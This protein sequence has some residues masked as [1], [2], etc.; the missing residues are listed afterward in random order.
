M[1]RAGHED[2]SLCFGMAPAPEP[3]RWSRVFQCPQWSSRGR[4][5]DVVQ[6]GLEGVREPRGR[7]VL[8]R[9]C[10]PG[11]V[12]V[13]R[14]RVPPPSPGCRGCRGRRRVGRLPALGT[15]RLSPRRP[16]FP[17]PAVSAWKVPS[18]TTLSWAMTTMRSA[19]EVMAR[20]FSADQRG[21]TTGHGAPREQ[22]GQLQ[23]VPAGMVEG[24]LLHDGGHRCHVVGLAVLVMQPV[25][26]LRHRLSPSCW[27]GEGHVRQRGPRTGRRD[28]LPDGPL[29]RAAGRSYG[30][31]PQPGRRGLP[32]CDDPVVAVGGSPRKAAHGV[33]RGQARQRVLLLRG[34]PASVSVKNGRTKAGILRPRTA[35]HGHEVLDA[36]PEAG[37]RDI[38]PAGAP[39]PDQIPLP[40]VTVQ[41]PQRPRHDRGVPALSRLAAEAARGAGKAVT[42]RVRCE[43]RMPAPPASGGL[44]PGDGSR[45]GGGLVRSEGL[46]GPAQS[47]TAP[48]LHRAEAGEGPEADCRT[49]LTESCQALALRP[50]LQGRRG[51]PEPSQ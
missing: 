24:R 3:G 18:C 30:P 23:A 36:G 25:G 26:G 45:R 32:A 37:P 28:H 19:T 17:P 13:F 31:P 1:S 15:S 5:L 16:L 6:V 50:Q 51:P 35:V 22:F 29:R 41:K 7:A 14:P 10:G 46:S 20:S 42:S 38:D 44:P 34:Q 48:V 2:R 12:G 47:W 39:G 4:R 40:R 21:K 8:S 43:V 9:L 49:H 27:W 33:Q 11:R